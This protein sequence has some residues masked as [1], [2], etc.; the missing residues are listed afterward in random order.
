[1]DMRAFFCLPVDRASRDRLQRLATGLQGRTRSRARWVD[2]ANYHV[3]LRF[4][5][6]I[7]PEL[8][9][10][11]H[12]VART[13]AAATPPLSLHVDRLSG[14]PDPRKPRVV[15]AGG[16][17]PD[18]FRRALRMLDEG[19]DALGFPRGREESAFHITL[20][21]LRGRPDEGLCRGLDALG[22]EA[23]RFT[24]D[25]LVLM[26]SVLR[27]DGARYDPLFTLAL[28]GDRGRDAPEADGA[29]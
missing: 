12:E 2:P 21:R 18:A 1:M 3:T 19:L 14:F 25:E 15:W 16:T 22:A 5:G 8:C 23:W 24:A 26:E 6:E 13:V 11:L 9:T 28:A 29:V 20:A 17:A 10:A 7:E 4:L 27:R